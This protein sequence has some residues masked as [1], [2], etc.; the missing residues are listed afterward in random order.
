MLELISCLRSREGCC[1]Y[2]DGV[3]PGFRMAVDVAIRRREGL[4]ARLQRSF[5]S[6]LSAYTCAE[7]G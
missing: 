2:D 5:P 6:A 4:V 3:V 7:C 1:A